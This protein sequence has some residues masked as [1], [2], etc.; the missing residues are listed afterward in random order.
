M[1]D[2]GVVHIGENSAEE[3]A[4]KLFHTIEAREPSK[5]KNRKDVLDLYA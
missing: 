5:A 1:A 3:V 2:T 4:L